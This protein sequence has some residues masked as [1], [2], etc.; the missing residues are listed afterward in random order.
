M[1]TNKGQT[2][3]EREESEHWLY[4]AIAQIQNAQEAK[5]FFEDLCTPTERQAMTDRW[6][7]VGPLKEGRPY[8]EI[9]EDTGV[10]ITT[11]GRVARCI[12]LGT[13]GYNLIYERIKK[14]A[15]KKTQN[16]SSKKGPPQ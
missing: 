14:Y 2:I 8:R 15:K 9:Y 16:R 4:E 5:Q 7:V 13:N 6:Q 12:H 11:I 1:K 10:S 3:K